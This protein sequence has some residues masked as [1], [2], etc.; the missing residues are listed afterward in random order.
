MTV[1]GSKTGVTNLQQTP[2]TITT[3]DSTQIDEQGLEDIGNIVHHTPGVSMGQNILYG[4][5]Y[6]RGVGTNNVFAGSDPSS[7]VHYDGVYMARP[8]TVFSDFLDIERVEILRGPQG[9]LYGRNAAGGTINVVSRLPSDTFRSKI[10]A[11][12]GEFNKQRLTINASGPL[13]RNALSAGISL[14][15]TTSDGYVTNANPNGTSKL[16]DEN[17]KGIAGKLRWKLSN[18]TEIIFSADY[19]DVDETGPHNKPLLKNVDGTTV[20]G[21]AVINDPFTINT[22]FQPSTTNEIHGGYAKILSKISNDLNFTSIL[23]YR[24][25]KFHLL[26]DTDFTEQGGLISDVMEDQNQTSQEFQ[27]NGKS[28]ALKWVAGLFYLNEDD[29]FIGDISLPGVAASLGAPNFNSLLTTDVNTK[30]YALFFQGTLA[31]SEKLSATLGVRYSYEKKTIKGDNNLNIGGALI[32]NFVVDNNSD[33]E[34]FTPKLGMDYKISDNTFTYLSISKGFKSGGFNATSANDPA[35]N[36]E[37]L[38][39]YEVGVKT[40]LMDKQLRLNTSAF[41]YSYTDLQVQQF[42]IAQGGAA[43]AVVENAANAKVNGLELELTATPS[44]NMRFDAALSYLDATYDKFTTARSSAPTVSV[45]A[46][47]NHLNN[48]PELTA[49]LTAHFYQDLNAGTLTYRLNYYWQTKEFYTPFNDKTTSQDDYSLVNASIGYSNLD[50]TMQIQL[51]ADNLTDE[52]YF[53][54]TAD[55]SPFGVTGQINPPRTYGIRAIFQM[56]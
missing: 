37:F 32:N 36:P 47:G 33:W 10:T 3:F 11:E 21:P 27:L 28:G 1:T 38:W 56:E 7:V 14:L 26:M 52:S 25:V 20:T 45:D 30:A 4:Q 8:L 12:Y 23:A 53:N 5:V 43:R 51:Y 16:N 22:P 24:G 39:A 54:S 18:N 40:D 34:A 17:K 6:I 42:E 2:I 31:M 50:E 29:K 55:F 44:A 48:S 49:N 46:S 19:L 13:T 15:S 9:T 41:Y 35:F